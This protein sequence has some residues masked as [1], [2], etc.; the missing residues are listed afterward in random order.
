MPIDPTDVK[1]QYPQ[2]AQIK[3]PPF[4]RAERAWVGTLRPFGNGGDAGV[5]Y[6]QLRDDRIINLQRGWLIPAEDRAPSAVDPNEPYLV[7]MGVEFTV[8]AL[9]YGE[10][11]HPEVYALSPEI[12]RQ[13]FSLH[14]HLRDDQTLLHWGRFIQGLCTDFAPDLACSSLVTFLDF[15][16][17]FLAKHL[18]W[19]RTRRL[20]DRSQNRILYVPAPGEEILDVWAQPRGPEY[21]I[22]SSPLSK[23]FPFSFQERFGWSGFWPGQFAPHDFAANLQLDPKGPCH[24]GSGLHYVGC[25]Q[26]SDRVQDRMQTE[27]LHRAFGA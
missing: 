14:P 1:Q 9:E 4:K 13:R 17:I 11:R 16:A 15:T 19:M 25:H 27:A 18:V 26:S 21:N 3:V 20:V 10:G 5:L 22:H 24:C 6:R 7:N 12:S 8:V 23:R 2:F